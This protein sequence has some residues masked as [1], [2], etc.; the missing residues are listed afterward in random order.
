MM[1][2]WKQQQ[3]AETVAATAYIEQQKKR[4]K[5]R[6]ESMYK[7]YSTHIVHKIGRVREYLSR[8]YKCKWLMANERRAPPLLICYTDMNEHMV[9]RACFLVYIYLCV[10]VIW[11]HFALAT[12]TCALILI[13]YNL[14]PNWLVHYERLYSQYSIFLSQSVSISL[15]LS[16]SLSHSGSLSLSLVFFCWCQFR[17]QMK[18]L[19]WDIYISCSYIICIRSSQ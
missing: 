11:F 13:T 10:S 9:P 17:H 15:S 1:I 5:R 4:L 19:T 8:P 3:I 6:N 7:W 12:R 18:S 14:T 16:P 2:Y